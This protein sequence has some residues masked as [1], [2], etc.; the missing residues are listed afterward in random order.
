MA[1]FIYYAGNR[2]IM[3]AFAPFTVIPAGRTTHL[4]DL[5]S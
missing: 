3:S 2:L 5:A 1:G 4:A